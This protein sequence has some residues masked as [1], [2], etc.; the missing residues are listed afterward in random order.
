MRPPWRKGQ[1]GNPGGRPRAIA[2]QILR[3]EIT[4]E[5]LVTIWQVTI[6][7]AKAG[8]ATAR[9]E[10]LDRLEGKPVQ[11]NENGDVG[12]FTGLEDVPTEELLRIVRR[13]ES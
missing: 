3:Q 10:I 2:T 8:D 11:R 5:Y 13:L 1:T 6:S 9:R 12:E 4:E 7:Q